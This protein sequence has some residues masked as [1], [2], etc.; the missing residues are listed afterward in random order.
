[1]LYGWLNYA[2]DVFF[3]ESL[4]GIS[5][6]LRIYSNYNNIITTQHYNDYKNK[7]KPWTSEYV[8][9]L[10]GEWPPHNQGKTPA[11]D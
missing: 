5:H 1:M 7:N 10:E 2:F 8:Y 6:P 9:D 11:D 3:T 4:F